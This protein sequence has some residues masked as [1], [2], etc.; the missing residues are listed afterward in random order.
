MARIVA[1]RS[2]IC[3]EYLANKKIRE[4]FVDI[5]GPLANLRE[6]IHNKDDEKNH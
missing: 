6:S 5:R 4:S 1:N 2:R 3:R